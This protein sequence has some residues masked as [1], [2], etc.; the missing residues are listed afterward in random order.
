MDSTNIQILNLG[1]KNR[2]VLLQILPAKGNIS[3]MVE[4]MDLAKELKLTDEEKEKIEYK[5]D[6]NLNFYWNPDKEH[7]KEIKLNSDKVKILKN[8]IDI[9]DKENNIS[10]ALLDLALE[11]KNLK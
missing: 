4:V 5:E 7:I 1:I 9:L 11:I 2:L 10:I 6:E 3:D 8:T